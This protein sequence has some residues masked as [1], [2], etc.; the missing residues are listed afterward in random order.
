MHPALVGSPELQVIESIISVLN[1]PFSVAVIIDIVVL[2]TYMECLCI[3][4]VI[5][6]PMF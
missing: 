4:P 5:L 2:L 6:C 3:V 1:R